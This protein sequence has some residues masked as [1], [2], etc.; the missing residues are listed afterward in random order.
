MPS[1]PPAPL[2]ERPCAR[3]EEHTSELQSHLNLVCR[4]LLEKKKRN[5]VVTLKPSGREYPSTAWVMRKSSE[6][7]RLNRPRYG[8]RHRLWGRESC[9]ANAR[10]ARCAGE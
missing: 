7:W 6:R 4:L 2:S 9:A 3:S 8:G 1:S 5:R 10:S